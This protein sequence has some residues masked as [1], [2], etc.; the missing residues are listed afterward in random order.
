MMARC[1]ELNFRRAFLEFGHIIISRLVYCSF[2]LHLLSCHRLF[3]H[4]GYFRVG[5]QFCE[6][7]L[8]HPLEHLSQVGH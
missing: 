1:L 4:G 3:E 2:F 8:T 6:L 7:L 5:K